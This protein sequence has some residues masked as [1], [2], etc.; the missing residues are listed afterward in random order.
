VI[1]KI[2]VTP[3][4]SRLDRN[5]RRRTMKLKFTQGRKA[6]TLNQ[7]DFIARGGGGEIYV[8]KNEVYKICHQGHM[9]PAKKIQELAVLDRTNIIRPLDTFVV[10]EIPPPGQTRREGYTMRYVEN[11]VPMTTFIPLPYRKRHKIPLDTTLGLVRKGQNGIQFIH[12]NKC[13]IVDNNEMNL[14][15]DTGYNEIYFIDVDSFKTPS[16]P[17]DVIMMSVKDPLVKTR[18]VQG[19]PLP[20]QNIQ[21]TAL[22]DWY[23]YGI[24]SF[25]MF[26]GMHPFK[27]NHPRHPDPKTSMIDCMRDNLSI[28]DPATKFP[29][30]AVMPFS[31]I[32]DVYMQWYRALFVEGKRVPPPNDLVPVI[33]IVNVVPTKINQVSGSNMFVINE[34]LDLH[35]KDILDYYCTPGCEVVVTNEYDAYIDGQPAQAPP[36]TYKVGFAGDKPIAAYIDQSR[37]HLQDLRTGQP[38]PFSANGEELMSTDGRLYIKNLSQIF[39]V[40]FSTISN[41]VLASPQKIV[42]VM[43]LATQLFD[44]VAI[45]SLFDAYNVTVFIGTR[46]CRQF[47]VR[48]LDGYKIV[49]AKHERRV[50]MVVAVNAQTGKYDRFVFRFARDWGGYDVRIVNDIPNLGLNFTVLR[51]HKVACITEKEELEIFLA[52]KDN[53]GVKQIDDPSIE[54]DMILFS[55]ENEVVFSKGSKL[56]SITAR[57]P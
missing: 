57:K 2:L 8:V 30:Q 47:Q 36:F 20:L 13:L 44:G 34:L 33:H 26:I 28:L 41:Q 54:G 42:D 27:G 40:Q 45:Q 31:V 22:S 19:N 17:A 51:N 11:P 46:Q 35:G 4:E 24:V 16:Y 37:V 10:D 6:V 14:L 38:I 56:Y 52:E 23:S 48:E 12:Q 29:K 25:M 5:Y 1:P 9:P 7:G 55:R 32:P 50:L 53:P 21:W 18:D 3:T 15:T 39:E 43:D 49:D